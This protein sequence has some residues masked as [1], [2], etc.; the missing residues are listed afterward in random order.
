MKVHDHGE[1][2]LCLASAD[3]F[4]PAMPVG[5]SSGWGRELLS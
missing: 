5:C 4:I 2:A 3:A 1:R